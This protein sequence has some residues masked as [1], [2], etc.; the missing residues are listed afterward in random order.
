VKLGHLLQ[1]V[2]ATLATVYEFGAKFVL[3]DVDGISHLKAATHYIQ[4]LFPARTE[5]VT[6]DLSATVGI[7][8]GSNPSSL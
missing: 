3:T 1:R 6:I 5:C 7:I 2:S 8:L 4:F